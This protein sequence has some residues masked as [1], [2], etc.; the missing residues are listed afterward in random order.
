MTVTRSLEGNKEVT[1]C[2]ESAIELD[3]VECCIGIK[4]NIV[5]CAQDLSDFV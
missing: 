5:F 4:T 2:D 3:L 1:S